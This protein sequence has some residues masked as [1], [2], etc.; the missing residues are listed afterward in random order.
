L[1]DL[2]SG[3]VIV[4]LSLIAWSRLDKIMDVRMVPSDLGPVLL[5]EVYTYALGACGL[6]LI[7]IGLWRQARSYL[8]RDR[9]R[10]RGNARSWSRDWLRGALAP[11]ALP[12]LMAGSVAVLINFL[13][14]WGF[15][16]GS[17]AFL[18]LWLLFFAWWDTGRGIWIRTANAVLGAA[19]IAGLFYGVF[20]F[21]IKIPLP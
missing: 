15:L 5:P 2:L 18:G 4:A 9:R 17:F 20:R 19:A 3:M 11:V 1:T 6:V 13:P 14:L 12:A 16:Y 7:G 10:E 21:L 8:S